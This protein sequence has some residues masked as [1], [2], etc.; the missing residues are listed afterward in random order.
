[1][2]RRQNRFSI[3]TS[4]LDSSWTSVDMQHG[5]MFERLIEEPFGGLLMC[6]TC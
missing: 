6:K 1:M 5:Y 3:A 4:D 2:N